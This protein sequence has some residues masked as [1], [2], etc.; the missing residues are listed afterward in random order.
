MRSLCGGLFDDIIN[1]GK[2]FSQ[3]IFRNFRDSDYLLRSG[4]ILAQNIFFDS[5]LHFRLDVLF[6]LLKRLFLMLT[7]LLDHGREIRKT[8]SGKNTLA[9]EL[10]RKIFA[11]FS[12]SIL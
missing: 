1:V 11:L 5:L 9:L 2:I 7:Y 4:F 8:L 10:L 6:I 3:I 12:H